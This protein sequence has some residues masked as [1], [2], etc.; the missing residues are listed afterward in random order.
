MQKE[1]IRGSLSSAS[2]EPPKGQQSLTTS[3]SLGF[4][5]DAWLT[6]FDLPDL[7]LGATIE[8]FGAVSAMVLDSVVTIARSLLRSP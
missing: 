7:R 4:G 8:S 2:V 1:P 5:D 3:R 6:S